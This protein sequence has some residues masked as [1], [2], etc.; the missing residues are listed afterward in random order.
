MNAW[1]RPTTTATV[2]QSSAVDQGLRSYMLKVYNY[3]ASGVLLTAVIAYFAG[4]SDAFLGVML[5]QEGGVVT[6]IAPL[7]YLVMFAPLG[8]AFFLMFRINTMSTST[9]QTTFWAY[10]ALMGL[11]L[12]TIF[13]IYTQTSILRVLF[14]T[15]GTFGLLS[16]FGYATKRDLTSM[17]TFLMVGMWA[18]LISSLVNVFLLKSSM[19]DLVLSC[20]GVLLALGFTAY[21]TQKIKEIY[22]QVG[23]SAD[24]VKRASI[25]GALKLYM[26]FIYLFINLLRLLGDRR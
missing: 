6:G 3:M 4:T 11:S 12:F 8:M 7:G 18:V 13:L 21:D 14:V 24:A 15:A 5:A 2:S 17:G 1:D 26:D 19:F 10:A 25:M 16:M 9:L 23:S 20:V 22:Y